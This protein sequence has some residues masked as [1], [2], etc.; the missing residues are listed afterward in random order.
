MT[1]KTLRNG[2]RALPL[3]LLLGAA[4]ALAQQPA[5]APAQPAPAQAPAASAQPG[6]SLAVTPPTAEHLAFARELLNQIGAERL[7]E[8]VVG[9][10]VARLTQTVTATRPELSNDL[11]TVMDSIRTEFDKQTP[12]VV[13]DAARVFSR[14]MTEQELRET[15]TFLKSPAGQKYLDTQGQSVNIISGMM[16]QWSRQMSQQMF[17]KAR[18][19]MKK[20]GHDI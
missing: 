6:M 5:P 12:L 18:A 17:E 8:T 4:P 13:E 14:A 3:A 9:N 11:K 1:N 7:I 16:E 20:K 10:M 15:V 19:E 2:L